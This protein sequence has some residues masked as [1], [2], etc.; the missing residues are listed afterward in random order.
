V[1]QSASLS[2]ETLQAPAAHLKGAQSRNC[3]SPHVP[4]PSQLRALANIESPTQVASPQTV[5][6]A[7]KRLQDPVLSQRPVRPQVMEASA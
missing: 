1:V 4:S 3:A 5:V 7:G 6:L 2:H